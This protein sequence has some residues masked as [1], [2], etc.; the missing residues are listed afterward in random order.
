[1]G[2]WGAGLYSNDF[3]EDFKSTIKAVVRLPFAT[4]RLVE[5]LCESE[6][7]ISSDPNDEDHTAFWL[8]LADQFHKRGIKSR[9]VFSRAKKIIDSGSDLEMLAEMGMSESNLKKR[10]KKLDELR[11]KISSPVPEKNRKTI[12]KPQPF[13]LH[14]GDLFVY[15]VSKSG[16]PI[17]PYMPISMMSSDDWK[18]EKWGAG[19]IVECGRAFDYLAWYWSIKLVQTLPGK[20]QPNLDTLMG[21][22]KWRLAHPGTCSKSHLKKMRCE[23]VGSLNVSEPATAKLFK[24]YRGLNH[25]EGNIY[26]I[27]DISICNT[28]DVTSDTDLPGFNGLKTILQS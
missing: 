2:T 11:T 8:V 6:Q 7:Q 16:E 10:G 1:M 15:P 19:L 17:N 20:K 4:K 18:H 13:L 21:K 23:T 22:L 26:A 14:A 28:L 9:E 24:K 25:E 12:E 5:I 27:N 3:A